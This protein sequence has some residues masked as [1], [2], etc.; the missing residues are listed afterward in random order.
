MTTQSKTAFGAARG[1]SI[2][3]LDPRPP[4]QGGR[5]IFVGYD[6]EDDPEHILWSKTARNSKPDPAFAEE[7]DE[8]GVIEPVLVRAN[9]LNAE[10]IFGRRRLLALRLCNERRI[11]RGDDIRALP[12]L[13]FRG[14]DAELLELLMAENSHREDED[15]IELARQANR[16][17]QLRPK[18]KVALAAN[19]SVATLDM[20]LKLLDL[21]P[22]VQQRVRNREIAPTAAVGLVKLSFDEQE[23]QLDELLE[24]QRVNGV[25]PTQREVTRTVNPD[26]AL[27]PTAKQIR[28]A[29]EALKSGDLEDPGAHT[30]LSWVL[31][32]T[33]ATRI[34]GLSKVLG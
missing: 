14:T 24:K 34:K 18:A 32:K 12:A 23:K 26:K 27:K 19:V 8:R 31:G 2:K 1:Q 21:S 28:V 9:G 22:K 6:T 4:S 17:L 13:T 29:L 30:M 11:E 3:L 25:K 16:L 7:I 15:P 33:Q 5:V 10:I 20:R